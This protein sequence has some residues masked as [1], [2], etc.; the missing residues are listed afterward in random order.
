MRCDN[1][2]VNRYERGFYVVTS[3]KRLPEFW[4]G[5]NMSLE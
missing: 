3:E 2:L 1:K 4:T 5:F